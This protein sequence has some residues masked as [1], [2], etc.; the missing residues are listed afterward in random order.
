MLFAVVWVLGSGIWGVESRIWHLAVGIWDLRSL[1]NCQFGFRKKYQTTDRSIALAAKRTLHPSSYVL[2]L[3]LS[4][5]FIS[6]A[7]PTLSKLLEKAGSPPGFIAMIRQ[8]YKHPLG[9]PRVNGHRLSS[10]L[11][12]R[13]LRQGCPLSPSLFALYIDPLL[14]ILEATLPQGPTASLH[15]FADDLAIHPTG[16]STLTSFSLWDPKMDQLSIK[17]NEVADLFFDGLLAHV[18]CCS[19]RTSST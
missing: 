13:G 3:D 17:F 14:R 9:T 4:K 7:H 11:Q 19:V 16:L 5:A 18:R 6:V 15:A 12:L 10:H 2:Y 1:S 8:L